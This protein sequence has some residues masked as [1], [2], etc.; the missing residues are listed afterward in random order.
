M[1]WRAASGAQSAERRAQSAECRVQ[2]AD[3]RLPGL[4]EIPRYFSYFSRVAYLFR[5]SLFRFGLKVQKTGV[6]GL[7]LHRQ[8]KDAGSQGRRVAGYDRVCRVR[9]QRRTGLL[10]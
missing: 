3:Y 10:E 6:L 2:G 5:S 4:D 9:G 1:E 8:E 7:W